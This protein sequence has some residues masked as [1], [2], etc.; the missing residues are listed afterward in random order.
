[1][2]NILIIVEMF[3]TAVIGLYFLNALKSQ[4]LNKTTVV[5]ENKK[6]LENLLKMRRVMLTEPLSEKS[7]PKTFSEVIG[8]EKGIQALIAALCGQNPQH[9]IIYGPP[10]VGKT[11]AARL[12][13]EYAKR[14]DKSP[15]RQEAKIIEIDATTVRFDDR[16]IADPLIGS[17]HDPIYQGAGPLGVAGI[18][19]PKIGA[20]TRAHGGVLF[21]DEIG[22]LHPIEM[23][24]LLKV[25]EDRK[26]LLD[27][28]YYNSCDQN[29][30]TYVREVFENGLPA[31][32]RLV[33]ATTRNAEEIIP[34]LRSRCVEVYFRGLTS[35]EVQKIAKNAIE[36]IEM[37]ISED[38]LQLI[39][40][41]SNNG[42][43]AVNLVQLAAGIAINER[44]EIIFPSDLEII[45]ENGQFSP[46]PEKKINDKPQV[47]YVN[48]LAIYGANMGTI[49][50]IEA[51][52]KKVSQ[53]KGELKITGIVHE[54]EISTLNRKMKR[55]STAHCSVENVI[56][57]IENKFD[58]NCS[59]YDLHI[60]FP[61]GVP[62]DGPSAGIGIAVAIY[63]A[64]KNIPIDNKIAMTGE[65]SLHGKV[66]P[67]GGVN[68]KIEAAIKAGATRIIIPKE[69]WQDNFSQIKGGIIIPVSNI[70][71]VVKLS[72]IFDYN[73]SQSIKVEERNPSVLYASS[74]N[75]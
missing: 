69:N 61:G 24:K 52:A 43:D 27:S 58:I 37:K 34:A 44:R 23:N 40:K 72:L 26:V 36:K 32:F 11:A 10:G 57:V 28:V 30:P 4:Q 41:Y 15:F 13:L 2:T 66:K 3:F 31:D 38:A 68:A 33:G 53:R 29:M 71:E 45:I 46:R 59:E 18:P 39:G 70:E 17:V 8:Q 35:E 5:Q 6:E 60:N 63:S 55:K 73:E 21:I 74:S 22:E 48:G 1:M 75:N 50:E 62:V 14:Q 20:V 67:I 65:I 9:V 25:M 49:I 19:Q 51:M 47:G 12:V 42:R 56:S 16:G 7:R 54:E 64:I